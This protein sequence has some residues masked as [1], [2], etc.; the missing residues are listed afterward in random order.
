MERTIIFTVSGLVQGVGF[1]YFVYQKAASLGLKGYAK[2]LPDGS[3]EV[4]VNTDEKSKESLFNAL[5]KGPSRS[6]VENVK[7]K[8]LDIKQDFKGFDIL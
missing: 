8:Y 3:V 5:K 4:V 7:Q 2:N 6:Y 1:R